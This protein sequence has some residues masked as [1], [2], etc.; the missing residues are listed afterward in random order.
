VNPGRL[1]AGGWRPSR[2]I[3][4]TSLGTM[5]ALMVA[6]QVV[7]KLAGRYAAVHKGPIAAYAA[8]PWVWVGVATAG[9]AMLCWLVTLRRLPLA[10]AYPWTALIYVLT[11]AASAYLFGDPL[12]LRFGLGL[13][14]IVVGVVFTSR[15]VE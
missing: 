13:A 9:V 2:A 11:P 14:L 10:A 6:A 15:G 12:T 3:A 7:F 4:T 5:I 1:S 8:N